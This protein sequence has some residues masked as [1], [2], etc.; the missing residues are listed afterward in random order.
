MFLKPVHLTSNNP[1]LFFFYSDTINHPPISQLTLHVGSGAGGSDFWISLRVVGEIRVTGEKNIK[2]G[3]F[4][5][6]VVVVMWEFSVTRKA[7]A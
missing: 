4:E 2:S 1:Y 7:H 3:V 5:S 6:H